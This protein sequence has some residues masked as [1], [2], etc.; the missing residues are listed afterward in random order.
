MEKLFI[1]TGNLVGTMRVRTEKQGTFLEILLRR[2]AEGAFTVYLVDGRGVLCEVA[3]DSKL[4]GSVFRPFDVHAVLLVADKPHE[5]EF[6]AEGGFIGRAKLSEQAKRDVR[7]LRLAAPNKAEERAAAFKPEFSVVSRAEEV[8]KPAGEKAEAVAPAP[9]ADEAEKAVQN[10]VQKADTEPKLYGAGNA[11]EAINEQAYP[12]MEY[13]IRAGEA[14]KE[15][16]NA[17]GN[18]FRAPEGTQG[19][20]AL[21]EILKKAD[22]LFRPLDEQF[23]EEADGSPPENAVYNPF[24]DAFP[25]SHWKKVNYPGTSR[26]YLEGEM[27]KNGMKFT[28]HALPGEYSPVA[29]MRRRG[30]THFYRAADGSGYWVRVQKR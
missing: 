16:E 4:R 10:A 2:A 9:R 22:E 13:A 6:M 7:I 14:R 8:K 25:A 24:P 18:A 29:P 30:F 17:F 3:L 26:F 21:D 19:A 1:L 11:A 12:A 27:E 28:L 23:K 5:T 15:E 20:R